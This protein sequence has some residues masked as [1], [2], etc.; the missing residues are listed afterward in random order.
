MY[1]KI[2]NISTVDIGIFTAAVSDFK[3]KKISKKK[4][5]KTGSLN[6]NL[7]KNIDIL[8]NIGKDKNQRPKYLAGFAAETGDIRNAKK[9]LVNKNCDMIIYNKISRNNKVFGMNDNK[10]SILTKKNIKNY[11]KSSKLHCTNLIIDS[12]YNEIKY[13]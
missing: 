12:I 3:N 8:E 11:A 4:I 2:K 10:I 7:V 13:K 5:K 9:K 6:I 1:K